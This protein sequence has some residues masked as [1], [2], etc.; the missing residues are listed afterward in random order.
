[1]GLIVHNVDVPD[2]GLGDALRTGFVNQNT[3]NAELYNT[4]VF[5]V[6]GYDLS[7]NDFTDVLL[8]KLNSL[9]VNGEANVKS[10]WNELDPTSDAYILNKPVFDYN[11]IE[12]S[13]V[14][15]GTG[16][17]FDVSADAFPINSILYPATPDEVTL[18]DPDPTVDID[19]IDLIVA[20]IPTA[21]AT[22]GTVGK[23]TGTPASPELVVP[24]DYDP[25][26]YYVIKQITVKGASSTP[27][28]ANNITVFNETGGVEWTPTLTS[29]LVINEIDPSSGVKCI[30][31]TNNTYSDSALFENGSS[32]STEEVDLIT[33][34]LKLKET[35][36]NRYIFIEFLLDG[37]LKNRYWFRSPSNSYD[38]TNLS[39]Q[40]LYITKS[41]LNLPI[42]NF[43]QLRIRPYFSS[44]GYFLDDIRI[45]TGSGSETLPDT[46]IQDAPDSNLYGRRKGLWELIPSE[47]ADAMLKATYDPSNVGGDVFLTSNMKNATLSKTTPIDADNL[48]LWDSVSGVFKKLSWSNIKTALKTYFDTVYVDKTT[49]QTIGGVKTFSS[50]PIVPTPTTDLQAATKKYVD[51]NAGGGSGDMLKATYDPNTI[52]G[53]AFDMGN[54]VETSTKKILTDTERTAITTN[55]GKTTNKEA[56]SG[57]GA[58]LYLTNQE[59]IFY[60]MSAPNTATTYT[61]SGTILSAFARVLINAATEPTVTGA[62][63]IK[64]HDFI[65]STDM[66]LTAW[67]NGN[68]VEFWFEE[69]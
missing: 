12:V 11:N 46:G 37:V 52:N 56:A 32:M 22:I 47:I 9:D 38:D 19:R 24:P 59:G 14:W 43:N 28:G 1:M 53:D 68:R 62:T 13:A 51:D 54:M 63:K 7:K 58:T 42:F 8:A 66:Y 48:T 50:S 25:S 45:F 64:G 31:A 29:N 27:D 21:P 15:T 3:M 26:I 69:I 2:S 61:T 60:D 55:S 35:V 10:D 23:I 65:A 36:K 16:F 30:E 41:T 57:T 20:I 34:N 4:A 18:D 49:A 39:Y 40:K 6:A 44:D 5:K 17:A 33:F 67:Y